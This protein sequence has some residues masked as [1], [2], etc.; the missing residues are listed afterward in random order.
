MAVVRLIPSQCTTSSA[1]F[2]HLVAYLVFLFTINHANIPWY[3]WYS[4]Y[5][6][7]LPYP[8]YSEW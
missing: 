4:S 2:Q 8:P 1:N 7:D 5:N 3:Y 6:V